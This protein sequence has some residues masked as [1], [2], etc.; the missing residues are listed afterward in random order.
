MDEIETENRASLR[1]DMD[2]SIPARTYMV[3]F[4]LEHET[5]LRNVSYEVAEREEEGWIDERDRVLVVGGGEEEEEDVE[6][7]GLEGGEE[8]GF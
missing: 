5:R 7:E 3:V 8:V 6:D 2:P 1:R 4:L